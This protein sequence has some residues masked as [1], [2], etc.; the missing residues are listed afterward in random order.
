MKALKL[1]FK[2]FNLKIWPVFFSLMLLS[3]CGEKNTTVR[4][5]PLGG[6]NQ[7]Q[8]PVQQP[9]PIP[10]PIPVPPVN[11]GLPVSSDAAVNA[12]LPTSGCINYLSPNTFYK[13]S[14]PQILNYPAPGAGEIYDTAGEYQ[15]GLNYGS[16]FGS[17][18]IGRSYF[19]D[20]L[21]ARKHGNPLAVTGYSVTLYVCAQGP[22]VDPQLSAILTP[23]RIVD[24]IIV[25]KLI[26]GINA[27]TT[28]DEMVAK[29]Y[30]GISGN[31]I[32]PQTPLILNTFYPLQ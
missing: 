2:A 17:T 6:N 14:N 15:L 11:P 8:N 18:Y 29:I 9:I 5:T 21:V 23:D 26:F 19:G 1:I 10:A 25:Q 16:V 30:F 24:A 12:A 28:P 13:N 27:T 4:S 22:T 32:Y 7:F 20:I 3:A 31:N